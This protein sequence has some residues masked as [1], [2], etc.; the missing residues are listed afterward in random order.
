M[1][2]TCCVKI[3]L[4]TEHEFWAKLILTGGVD[5]GRGG[6]RG[7]RVEAS[8]WNIF[9]PYLIFPLFIRS[10]FTQQFQKFSSLASQSISFLN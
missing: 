8:R 2:A 10:H 4:F 1:E 6:E 9:G 5:L 3:Q 7:G